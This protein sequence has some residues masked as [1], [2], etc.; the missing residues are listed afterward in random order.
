MNADPMFEDW[1]QDEIGSS[2]L[3]WMEE[4]GAEIPEERYNQVGC[5]VE[6][7]IRDAIYCL[8]VEQGWMDE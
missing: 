4:A 8:L 5:D 6:G 2:I 1:F 7:H 3:P